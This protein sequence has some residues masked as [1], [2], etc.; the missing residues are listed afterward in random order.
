MKHQSG[1]TLI[2]LLVSI[3]LLSFVFV[4]LFGGLRFGMRAWEH[5]SATADSTDTVR[6][7][8]DL[9]RSEIERTCP[10]RLP[11]ATP[12]DAPRVDFAGDPSALRFLGPAPGAAGGQRCVPVT[13]SVQP[14]GRTE[15][16]I[17]GIDRTG[18]DLLRHAQSV[19]FAY[20]GSDGAWRNSWH[21]QT[22]LPALVRL[23]VIFPAGDARVWPEL[24]LAPRISA[25]ADC[26]Y[27]ATTK[28][29]RGG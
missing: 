6:T 8:Q 14:D 19:Q 21:G 12:Q 20:L 2:E 7:V 17:L 13:L 16:F 22:D 27:D 25:E 10:R 28:S 15:R 18:S 26:I 29:C 1:F 5:G 4:L 3:T 23:R 11:P 24:F 9:L